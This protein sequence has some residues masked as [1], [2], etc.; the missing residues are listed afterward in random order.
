MVFQ[1]LLSVFPD[2]NDMNKLKLFYILGL[3]TLSFACAKPK[4]D[5]PVIKPPITKPVKDNRVFLWVDASANYVPL[6]RQVEI[7]RYVQKAKEIGVTDLVVDIKGTSGEVL[8]DSAIAPMLLS[9]KGAT[10]TRDFDY[11]GI[12]IQEAHNKG[13]KVSVAMNQF[14]GGNRST[15]TGTIFQDTE[16]YTW[17]SY[18]YCNDGVIRP[19]VETTESTEI[20]LNPS[21]KVVRDYQSSIIQ[22]VITKYPTLDGVTLDRGRFD[23]GMKGDYSNESRKQFETFL[24]RPVANFP[25]DILT[26][27]ADGSY[28]PGILFAKWA[29][30]R[31]SVIYNYINNVRTLVKQFSQK[32]EFADYCG[33]WY[34]SYFEVG[35]NWASNRYSPYDVAGY[36]TWAT[37]TYFKYGFAQ[38]LDILLTGNYSYNVTFQE[39]A[40]WSVESMANTVNIATMKDTKVHAGI[41]LNDYVKNGVMDGAQVEKAIEM[42]FRKSEGVMLFDVIYFDLYNCWESVGRGI[43]RGKNL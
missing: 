23:S 7:V 32:M 25:Q 18:T 8:Y 24:G 15:R 3:I 37:T 10:R 38:L 21:L 27:N 16:K 36:R 9:W 6:S 39:S 41:Y 17:Q 26:W 4:N 1:Y 31:C 11:L 14:A 43:E 5:P 34:S 19:S 33:A 28:Q 29:E 22:E 13:L 40:G 42:C 12:F 20:M 2:P 30:W 35:V